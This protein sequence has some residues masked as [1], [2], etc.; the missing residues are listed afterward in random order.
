MFL[1]VKQ[2]KG[3]CVFKLQLINVIM[4]DSNQLNFF[5]MSYSNINQKGILKHPEWHN[6]TWSAKTLL[7]TSNNVPFFTPMSLIFLFKPLD[8]KLD[9][10]Y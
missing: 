2:W 8:V 5:W 7:K 10:L 6:F 4:N 3:I 1:N 9:S